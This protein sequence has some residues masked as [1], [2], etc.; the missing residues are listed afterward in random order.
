MRE[1]LKLPIGIESFS[2]I[3]T[4]GFYYVDKTRL[5]EQLLKNPSEVN[6]FTRPR[7]FGKSLN[8][9]MLQNFFEIGCNKM[10]FDGLDIFQNTALCDAYMGQFPVISITLKGVDGQTY[11]DAVA[12]MKDIIGM[13]AARFPFLAES[14]NLTDTEK[15]LYRG[16]VQVENGIFSMPNEALP[17]ALRNI[18]LLLA[19]HFQ[20]EVIILIDEYDVP[21]DKAFQHGYYNEMISLI[22]TMLGNALKTNNSL[23]FAVLTG[24]LRITK[25]SVFTGLNNFKIYSNTSGNA[26]VRRFIDMAGAQ[27]RN[28]MEDLIAGKSI[29][30]DIHQELTY[31]ELDQSIENLWSVLFTT[32]YLT[33]KSGIRENPYQ[34]MIPNQEIRGLFIDQIRIWFKETSRANKETISTFCSAFPERNAAVIET[35]F[36][37]Y[38]WNMISVRDN[39]TKEKK[40]NFYHGILLGLLRFKE[41]WII[42][43]NAESGIGYSDILIKIPENRIGIV[44]ELKYADDR[45]LDAACD[46]ALAQIE[47]QQYAASLE[48]DGMK[49]II[50]YGIACYKKEC[51]VKLG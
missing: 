3:R 22:R 35:L 44:I 40:E 13:E 11:A 9:S 37:D 16:Y 25:E 15:D 42:K 39:A 38:L 4:S 41:N 27:T 2:K 12:A 26:I 20:K 18:S 21:L 33:T 29:S 6:L 34:L 5:I 36:D 10:L 19:K 45:N 49:T 23:K 48:E 8:M 24:C 31:N 30:K 32:G 47:D 17:A 50:K 14:T 43:S 46:K 28:E 7:R 51:K 1:Q